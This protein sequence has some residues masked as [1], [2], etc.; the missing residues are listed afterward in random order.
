MGFFRRSKPLHERLAEEGG[1]VERA[2]RPLFT[3]FMSEAGIHGIPRE[4]E[5]DAVVAATAPAVAGHE[6]SFVALPDGTLIVDEEEGDA[7]LTP[8][9]EAVEGQLTAPYR[10]QA[11]RKSD[12]VWAVAAR[13]IA[14]A[15][16]EAEGDELELSR[17]GA[18]RALAVDGVR[19]FGTIPALEA[20]A[21]GDAVVRAAR[22]DGDLWEIRVDPL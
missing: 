19:A 9:A 5:Y 10:A 7:D 22:L 2:T 13:R 8:L 18:E 20:L 11:V 1:L 14:V 3:G 16:F 6:V 15:R 4:R 12:E 17:R 21:E